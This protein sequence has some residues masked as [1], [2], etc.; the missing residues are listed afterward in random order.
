ML[1]QLL[2]IFSIAYFGDNLINTAIIAFTFVVLFPIFTY[3]I[4]QKIT[5]AINPSM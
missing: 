5:H 3:K 4:T 1:V 2:F